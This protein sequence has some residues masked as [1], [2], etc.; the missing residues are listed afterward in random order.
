MNA[1]LSQ[2]DIA[3]WNHLSD[4]YDVKPL[5]ESDRACLDAVRDV[6]EKFGCLDRFGVNLLH[7]HFEMADDEL[8]IEQVDEAG[9]RLVT[10]P[11]KVEIVRDQMASAYETQWHWQR[12]QQGALAQICV[13]RCF[14]GTYESPGHVNKHVGW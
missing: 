14:P 7:K 9:R 2:A 8:L 3:Q 5:N 1:P 4:I 13:A 6:L 12:D 10:K 11:V